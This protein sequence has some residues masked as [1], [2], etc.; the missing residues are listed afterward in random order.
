MEKT[1]RLVCANC[2]KEFD[3]PA[4][5]YRRRIKEGHTKFFC[6]RS[7]SAI[8]AN[9]KR[10]SMTIEKVCPVCGKMF[11]TKDNRHE[12]TFC[13][14]SC[15]SKGSM[16]PKRIEAQ[17]LSGKQHTDNLLSPS[18]TLKLREQWK[19]VEVDKALRQR[20][21]EFEYPL[22]GYVFD[23][24]LL[25]VNVLVEFDGPDHHN[26]HQEK[27]DREKDIIARSCGFMVVHRDVEPA[28][29]ISPSAIRGL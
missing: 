1:V 9:K 24:A 22:G 23:L 26:A 14:R 18:A 16:T 2:G 7:C 12:A 28:T 4:G 27:I 15:A 13:S 20:K 11:T 29:V 5:E 21:H 8:A 17:S 3:K 6:S 25:D 19:Y 10:K